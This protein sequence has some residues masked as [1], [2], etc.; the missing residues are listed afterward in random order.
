MLYGFALQYSRDLIRPGAGPG[1]R[2]Q[3]V[4]IKERKTIL[5]MNKEIGCCC[6]K[7]ASTNGVGKSNIY[8]EDIYIYIYIY[9]LTT[10]STNH[11]HR[12]NPLATPTSC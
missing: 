3:Y 8:Y 6:Q 2:F 4:N 1:T 11:T 5:K 12:F 7:R 9:L 10:T